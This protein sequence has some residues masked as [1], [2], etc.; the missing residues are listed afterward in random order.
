MG[1]TTTNQPASYQPPAPSAADQAMQKV[2]N[3]L[4]ELCAVGKYK[5]ALTELYADNARHVE[6]ME[7]PDC[8][9]I[10]EGKA[11][12]MEK[13]EKFDRT[14]TVHDQSCSKPLINGDQFACTMSM[15][16]TC[17][18]GPMAGQR[19]KM[20]ETALYTVKNGKITEGKFFYS[21]GG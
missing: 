3:R 15:D 8:S 11:A 2:A 1:T 17:S 19:M 4:T 7:M 12:L 10:T 13:G 18:E 20:E 9:R 5:E 16:V 14:T 6:A 21:C